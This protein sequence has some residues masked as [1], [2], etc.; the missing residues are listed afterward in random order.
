MLKRFAFFCLSIFLVA[1]CTSGPVKRIDPYIFINDNSSKA[2]LVDKLLINK[3]DYT[4]LR[5]HNKQMII[6]HETQNAYFYRV[7]EFGDKPGMKS[8]Y[9]MD[10][11]KNEF[12][13]QVGKKEWIF[14][15]RMLSRKKIVLKPK[16]Q[17]YPYTIVLVPFPEY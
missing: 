3:N 10:K 11:S 1:G 5:F 7:R 4:P 15:I 17:S 2:W 14:D 16:H 6:F 8:Y 12:G 13:F 9:W